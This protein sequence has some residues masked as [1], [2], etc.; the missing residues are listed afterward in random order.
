MRT[1]DPM[2]TRRWRLRLAGLLAGGAFALH[3]LR[4]LVG[5]GDHSHGQLGGQ[6][7]AYMTLLAPVVAVALMLVAADFCARLIGARAGRS[8]GRS[9]RPLKLW[10]MATACLL[11]A[12]GVQETL[13]GAL[14][15]GHPGGLT[16][17]LGHGGFAAIPLA[18]AIG[19]AITLV[20]RGAQ[21]A[22]EL[23]AEPR[24]RVARPRPL[25]SLAS[26]AAAGR[27]AVH[28]IA[29]HLGARGPPLVSNP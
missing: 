22:I 16:G 9:P 3:Q 17:L 10:A 7:H 2:T 24:I 28:R 20:V 11:A 26:P 18:A 6:G 12:Y 19:L 21:H 29:R 13:E 25:V 23:A 27:P 4:Y 15:P 14:S 5:Y 8:P 1:I